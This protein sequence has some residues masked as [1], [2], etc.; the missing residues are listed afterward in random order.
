MEEKRTFRDTLLR[1]VALL[2]LLLVLLLGAWGIILLAFNFPT[3][4]STVGSNI[5]SIFTGAGYSTP[6]AL[7]VSAPDTSVSG[8]PVAISWQHQNASGDYSYTVSYS[9]Q[10][11]L[12]VKAPTPAG[13]YQMVPCSTPF[14]YT[15]ASDKITLVPSVSG[16]VAVQAVFTVSAQKLS[17][18]AITA[19]GSTNVSITPIVVAPTDNRNQSQ[20]NYVP[21]TAPRATLHGYADLAVRAV[22]VA[23]TNYS[24]RS[25]MSVQFEIINLGTN[26][27]PAGWSFDALL[28]LSPAY[29]Y[30]AT[31][32]QALYPGDKIVYTLTFDAP[33]TYNQVCTQQYPNYDCQTPYPQY[34]YQNN[35]QTCYRYDGYQN[36]PTPCLDENGYPITY[37]NY[38]YGNYDKVY[39]YGNRIVTITAD[40]RGMIY[41][42]NRANNTASIAIPGY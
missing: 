37:N 13:Q 9:C 4:A 2:G 33:N 31:A 36:V 35:N 30:T 42:L 12:S 16:K 28:P 17:D 1:T 11:G 15:G 32:Q 22:T 7:S 5:A 21:S 34:P 40:L 26:M 14:N 41:D 18:N 19:S 39:P 25:R 23:P 20:G 38:N 24:V 3:I 10:A 29:T 6:E 8:Q 27:A